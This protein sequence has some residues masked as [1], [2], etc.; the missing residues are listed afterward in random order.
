MLNITLYTHI[1]FAIS[2]AFISFAITW[3]MCHR[4]A[5][6]DHP[7][8]RSSHNLAV[9][10]GGGVAIVITFFIGMFTVYFIGDNTQIQQKYMLGFITSSLLIASVSFYDDIHN[11]SAKFKLISQLIAVFLVLWSGIVLDKLALPGLG[12][13]NLGWAGYLLS[14]F[15]IVGLTNAYNFMDGL[16]GLIGGIT[17]IASLFFMAIC[18]Y[19]GSHFIYITCYTLLAGSLGFLIL[20]ISPAKIFMGDVGSTF[21]GFTF[22]TLSII[23]TRYDESHV[24]FFVV[25]LLLFNIIYDVIFTLVR[26]RLNGE[27]LT[28]AHRTHLYQLMNQIGYSHLEVSLT[29]YCMAFLQGLGAI[30]MIQ[31]SESNQLYTFIPFFIFQI[32]YTT[33]ILRKAKQKKII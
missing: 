29:H 1:T 20:N 12:I 24:T 25:P 28:Q 11:K 4:V 27:K 33:L 15:W 6:M 8:E 13:I 32:I 3:F 19:E 5:I 14:L 30:W 16:D 10:R 2:L 23:A 22:A 17:V 9:P 7:N 26:R 21:I 18:Y 31:L